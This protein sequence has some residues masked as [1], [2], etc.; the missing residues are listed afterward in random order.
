MNNYI[1]NINNIYYIFITAHLIF[2]TLIPSLT[3]QNL[4]LDTIEALAW[5]NNLDW[6]FNKHPPMSAFLSEVFFQIFGSQDWAYYLLSQISVLIAFFYV[7]KFSKEFFKNDLLALISVLLIEAIYFYNFTTPEFNVNVCQLPFWSLTVYFSWKIYTSKEIKFTDCFLIGLFAAFGFLSKYLFVYLLVSIDLFFIYLIFIK[8]E[9][10]FDFK[11]LITLEVFFI[12][13]VPHLIWLNNNEFITITY[14]LDRTGLEQSSL[15]DHI[16]FPLIFLI[17]QI[18]LLIPF[19]ILVWLLVKKIKFKF[20]LKDK[21]LLFLLAINILPILL[22]FLTSVFTGSKIR[23]M[24]MT[25]FY[26]FFGV[27]FVYLFQNK[28]NVKKLKPF[29]IGFIFLFFLY[30][31][32]YAYI[33]ISKDDKRTDYP[34][35]KIAIKTQY[36]WDQQFSSQINVVYGNEWNAGNLSYHLKSRPV[37]EGIIERKKLDQLK[38][39]MCLDNVCVG[40]K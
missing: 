36:A 6:G 40:S 1:K 38:D 34:G 22:V 23:T 5:G 14:A 19:L 8:R 33:S 12:V 35:K 4:P 11:Y 31:M 15:I 21:R 26:L 20:D 17:K 27:L 29:M 9:R 13:L 32:L 28:I 7:F 37:W 24:W 25:P 3:N 30:P 16:K 39:Y 2:W 10:K 18:G